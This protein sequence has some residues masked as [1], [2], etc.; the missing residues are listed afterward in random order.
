M[1]MSNQ[2]SQNNGS[3]KENCEI[4]NF[5]E[6]GEVA[7][8]ESLGSRSFDAWFLGSKA[9]NADEFESLIVEA[10][11]DHALWRRNF[12]PDDS[13][14]VTKQTKQQLD[15]LETLG[16]LRENYR[17]LLV[18]LK[19]SAPCFSMRYQGHMLYDTTMP[20]V[21]GYFAAMLYNPNNAT[22]QASTA[23]TLLEMLVGDDLC[24]MLGYKIPD[25]AEIKKGGIRPW[26]HL[27]GGGT[28]SN[29]EAIWSVRNLKFY[30]LA[31]RA[32]LQNEASLSAAKDIKISPLTGG[33]KPLIELDTWSLL[34]LKA[35]DVLALPA[36]FDREYQIDQETLTQAL[37][38]YS[39]Q[40]LGIAE[41]SH[42]FLSD[43]NSPV[44]LVPATRHYSLPKAAALLGI[45]ESHLINVPLDEDARM[46]LV[47]AK[48]I[49]QNCL[50]EHRP[51]YTVV[52]VMGTTQESAVDPLK[53]ILDLRE[54]LRC[55]GL[56]FTIHAD[57]AWG[58]YFASL[59]RS[60]EADTPQRTRPAEELAAE[61]G[62][63][64]YVTEQFQVLGN[65]DSITVDPHKSGYIPYPAGALCYRNS[66]M[67]N[68]IKF[69][70]PVVYQDEAEP[71]VGIYGLE[72]SKPGAA[73]A[74]VYLSHKVIRPTECG[75][76][77]ILRRALFNC[78][79]LYARL[80]CMA[81]PSDRFVVVPLPRLPIVI[82]GSGVEQ[83]IQFI[84]NRIDRVNHDQLLADKEAMQLLDEIGP[85]QNVIS[86]AFNFRHPD[87]SLNTDLALANRL[88][89][90][91]YGRLSID[92]DKDID[93]YKLIV[94]T[95]EFNSAYYGD[96]FVEHYK[97][98]LLGV[99]GA[100]GSSVTVLRSAVLN[101]WPIETSQGSFLD[102]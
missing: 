10:I 51:V 23:T 30:P 67:R 32:A 53:D 8:P 97:Q 2:N 88:N 76:G 3:S 59:L 45:G 71:A 14:N 11:R 20:S 83:Q 1:I 102:K 17:S 74:S 69:A 68:L 95:A 65:A 96:M 63:S 70:A 91:I 18:F 87:G 21:L 92:P 6:F 54:A 98:R 35:D 90:A 72:G 26:G 57:A 41:F 36:R 44:I 61:A 42:R 19:K 64:S 47:A 7:H 9:E 48:Q 31:L 46:S 49:L 28:V 33:S 37:S 62:L 58:G 82:P 73:A 50:A 89:Q 39:L 86:Y 27:T 79:R 101:P 60:D 56:E 55:Q 4:S 75:H 94:S 85:D 15:Y 34:N 78:K 43:I 12:H 5:F 84:C 93:S 52:C 25:E 81:R 40:S 100:A 38:K 29:I 66:A 24:Q 16:T 80:L 77:K 99:S 22:F 13:I